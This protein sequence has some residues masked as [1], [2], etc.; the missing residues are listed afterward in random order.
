M[1]ERQLRHALERQRFAQPPA[2]QTAGA[3][4]G[5][6]DAC[7]AVGVGHFSHVEPDASPRGV[8]GKLD[9]RDAHAVEA[10]IAELAIEYGIQF[11][12]EQLLESQRT[13]AR[14][15]APAPRPSVT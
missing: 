4:E 3:H 10:A 7:D 12:A 13:N 2:E 6:V 8:A 9:E 14:T 5:L 1:A 11:F 15:L